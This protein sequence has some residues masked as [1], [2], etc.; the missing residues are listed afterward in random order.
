MEVFTRG[1]SHFLPICSPFLSGDTF[2][3]VWEPYPANDTLEE[4]IVLFTSISQFS[5]G[6]GKSLGV[7]DK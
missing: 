1:L 3:P 4:T 2:S 7:V 5:K 6:A